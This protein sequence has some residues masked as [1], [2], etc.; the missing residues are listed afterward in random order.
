LTLIFA[1]SFGVV[2]ANL[3]APAV[4]SPYPD[5]RFGVGSSA[6]GS[7]TSF[8]AYQL[9]IGWYVD[10]NTHVSPPRP[11]GIQHIQTIRLRQNKVGGVYQPGYVMTPTL[12]T[13]AE[14]LGPRVQANPGA[15]WVIGNEPDRE[16]VQDDTT[17]EVFAEAYHDAYTFIKGIDPTARVAMPGL[18]EITPLR[19][20]YLDTISSTYQSLYGVALPVDVWTAHIYILPE[21]QSWGAHYPVGIQPDAQ[22]QPVNY[23][24]WQHDDLNIFKQMVRDMRDWMNRS[25]Y[26][27]T[28]LLFTEFG[29]LYP[30]GY[31]DLHGNPYNP[32]RVNAFMN[33]VFDFFRTETSS[34][35]GFPADG[36][37]LVQAWAW[38]SVADTAFNGTLFDPVTKQLTSNGQNFAAYTRNLGPDLLIPSS[39]AMPVYSPV[40]PVTTTISAHVFNRGNALYTGPYTV[41]IYSDMAHTQVISAVNL[42]N[43]GSQL[44]QTVQVAWPAL[45]PGLHPYYPVLTSGGVESNACNNWGQGSVL[46]A[47]YQVFLPFISK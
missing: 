28:P 21:G 42:S 39:T 25:G 23:Q 46:V 17:P 11:N 24:D 16:E 4:E 3:L 32:A 18:V 19:L 7:M 9:G 44:T 45:G 8:A 26:R 36:D 33:G 1:A 38:Y 35:T 22:T 15:V 37:R 29:I 30:D 2:Q 20:K 41:T 31:V 14:G 43:L 10:W 34:V 40:N 5:C 47:S 13:G 6:G 12:T 27:N